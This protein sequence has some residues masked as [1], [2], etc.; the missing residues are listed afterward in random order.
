[1][2]WVGDAMAGLRAVVVLGVQAP[3]M[4]VIGTVWP[5]TRRSTPGYLVVVALM[6]IRLYFGHIR[7]VRTKE[8]EA[9]DERKRKHVL[10]SMRNL[11]RYERGSSEA[12]DEEERGAAAAKKRADAKK[13]H[14][15]IF[16]DVENG[17][18]TKI[19]I[20]PDHPDLLEIKRL[21]GVRVA[22][23]LRTTIDRTRTARAGTRADEQKRLSDEDGVFTAAEY[24]DGVRLNKCLSFHK[25]S[26]KAHFPDVAAPKELLAEAKVL[27]KEIAGARNQAR[28]RIRALVMPHFPKWLC[29]TLLLMVSETLWGVLHSMTLS[30]PHTLTTVI[31]GGTKARAEL[32][33]RHSR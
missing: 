3:A 5:P 9:E 19:G 23:E 27:A 18:V 26:V 29:G 2:A 6:Y 32:S 11:L 10:V 1:M 8:A 16:D 25:E 7:T 28:Q 17:P 21:L 22:Q 12:E 13:L 33:H 4:R 24:A 20:A 30:L 15:L 14:G 31:D